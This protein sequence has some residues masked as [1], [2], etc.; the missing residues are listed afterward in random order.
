MNNGPTMVT[1]TLLKGR[2][3][4]P[5]RLVDGRREKQLVEEGESM[6]SFPDLSMIA[7]PEEGTASGSEPTSNITELQKS[8]FQQ[9]IRQ[10]L[11]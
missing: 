11:R 5:T 9:E 4:V 7:P 1:S 6:P 8:Q 2:S 3:A 10:E